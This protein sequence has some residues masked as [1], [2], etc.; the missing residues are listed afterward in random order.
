[1]VVLSRFGGCLHVSCL[2]VHKTFV[3]SRHD[4]ATFSLCRARYG[5]WCD[6]QTLAAACLTLHACTLLQL[7]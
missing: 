7:L 6:G 3:Q 1:M 5:K 4:A 2:R